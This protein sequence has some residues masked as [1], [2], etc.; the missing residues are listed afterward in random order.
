[1]VC[2]FRKNYFDLE[3]T[4]MDQLILELGRSRRLGISGNGPAVSTSQST[5]TIEYLMRVNLAL[6]NGHGI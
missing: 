2:D 4:S 3:V 1:M 6:H 5:H